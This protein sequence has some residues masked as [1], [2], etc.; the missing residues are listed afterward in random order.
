MKVDIKKSR[1][2]QWFQIRHKNKIIC[3]GKKKDNL[4]HIKMKNAKWDDGKAHT[5]EDAVS[6]ITNNN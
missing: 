2:Y 3:K 5:G 1:L 4:R 6:H